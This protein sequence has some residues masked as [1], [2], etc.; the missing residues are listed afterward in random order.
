MCVKDFYLPTRLDSPEY[1][2]VPL[3]QTP[4]ATQTKYCTDDF[5]VN[6]K[7]LVEINGGIYG[8]PQAD[9]L[10]Q[11]DLVKILETNCYYMTKTSCFFKYTKE[12]GVQ[13]LLSILGSKYKTHMGWSGT[14][15]LCI[16]FAWDYSTRIRTVITF[17][18][19]FVFKALK[20]YG[21]DFS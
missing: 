10:A 8:L 17:M 20:R 21:F 3:A 5:L 14:R 4:P 18:P 11:Q 1:A 13:H 16:T 15:F 9:L 7:V 6:G 19:D 12:A 2:W